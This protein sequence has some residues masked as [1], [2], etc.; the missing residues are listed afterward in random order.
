MARLKCRKHCTSLISNLQEMVF[1][2]TFTDVTLACSEGH[3]V[4]V[5]SLILCVFS[6][7][8]EELSSCSNVFTMT[9]NN[10]P[11]FHLLEASVETPP[12]AMSVI[13]IA[14]MSHLNSSRYWLKYNT[15]KLNIKYFNNHIIRDHPNRPGA[16][17]VSH[18][19]VKFAR[20]SFAHLT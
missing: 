8:F 1:K 9:N 6:Q 13:V 14:K 5:H 2:E 11:I 18:L 10:F 20:R 16:H 15:T 4:K 12:T 7:Y 17:W 3:I 19:Q